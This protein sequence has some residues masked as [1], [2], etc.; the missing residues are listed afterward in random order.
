MTA[1]QDG[2]GLFPDADS[3]STILGNTQAVSLHLG[4][5]GIIA[6][7]ITGAQQIKIPALAGSGSR[8][9]VASADGTLS[10]P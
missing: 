2:W 9:V 5:H 1:F 7:T 10:A 3:Y 8:T 6:L 4:T